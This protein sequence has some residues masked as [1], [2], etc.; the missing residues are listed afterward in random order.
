M[1]EPD[2]MVLELTGGQPS[3]IRSQAGLKFID[4]C[5]NLVN[6]EGRFITETLIL[7]DA[8]ETGECVDASNHITVHIFNARD[9]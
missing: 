9:G 1:R 2:R 5:N 7:C 4:F 3:F 8:V 6:M